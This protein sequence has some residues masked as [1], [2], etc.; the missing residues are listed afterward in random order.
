MDWG[1]YGAF[2]AFAVLLVLVPGPDLA[3]VAKNS[4]AG[5]RRRGAWAG[6]GVATSN[7]VQGCAAALGLGA[8]ILRTQPLF[9]AI[10]WAG[11]AYLAYLGAQ[12]LRDAIRPRPDADSGSRESANGR[13]TALSGWRQGFLSNI[14]NPKVIAFY[15]AVLPQFLAA[16]STLV[17]VLALAVTHAVLSLLYLLLVA[18]LLA[19][20][21]RLF[22]RRPVRR[23]LDAVTGTVLVAFSAKLATEAR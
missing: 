19:K 1:N 23:A 15:L 11:V 9:E 8:V 14:T 7:T 20:G 6:A 10:R 16:D 13:R 21:R 17:Q 2:V 4:L 3:V 18:Y 22:H 12:A 5:G